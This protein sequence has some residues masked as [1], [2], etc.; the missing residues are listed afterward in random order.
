MLTTEHSDA[1]LS[2]PDNI[3][4]DRDGA[5][6]VYLHEPVEQCSCSEFLQ[7]AEQCPASI[8]SNRVEGNAQDFIEQKRED[9]RAAGYLRH[10]GD[11]GRKLSFI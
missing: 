7:K 3:L 1:S 6:P 9:G 4:P 10:T 11:E 5:Y 8:L 2:N